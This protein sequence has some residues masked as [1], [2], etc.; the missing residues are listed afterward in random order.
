[1]LVKDW[2]CSWSSCLQIYPVLWPMTQQRWKTI[3]PRGHHTTQQLHINKTTRGSEFVRVKSQLATRGDF[4]TR[5]NDKTV[6]AAQ[7][8]L[9]SCCI[10]HM[11]IYMSGSMIK[12]HCMLWKIDYSCLITRVLYIMG[13]LN[14]WPAA[15]SHQPFD[16][17]MAICRL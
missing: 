16:F 17:I 11:C 6:R 12:M 1:M 8:L 10:G 4:D 5:H 14:A 3:V 7:D 13:S 2:P 9:Q 15:C